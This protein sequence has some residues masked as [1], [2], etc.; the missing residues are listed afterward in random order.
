MTK[1]SGANSAAVLSSLMACVV[2]CLDCEFR[3]MT[4]C[5]RMCSLYFY[6]LI[7]VLVGRNLSSQFR[8]SLRQFNDTPITLSQSDQVSFLASS[9]LPL[10]RRCRGIVRGPSSVLWAS[11]EMSLA[12]SKVTPLQDLCAFWCFSRKLRHKPFLFEILPKSILWF[13]FLIPLVDFFQVVLKYM[14]L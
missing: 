8:S 14:Y 3:A 4:K 6:N 12:L 10:V 1:G 11:A 5:G 9:S 2:L 7:C 13:S